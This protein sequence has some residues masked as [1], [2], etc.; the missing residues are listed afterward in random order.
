MIKKSLIVIMAIILVL[1]D[2]SGCTEE[3]NNEKDLS[4]GKPTITEDTVLEQVILDGL[5]LVGLEERIYNN[6]ELII[7]GD[8]D[9]EDNAK[10]MIIN[11]KIIIDQEYNKQ[12]SL[13]VKDSATL[14][15]DNAYYE[16][17]EWRWFNFNYYN[18]AKVQIVDFEN[19][20][21]PWQTIESNVHAEFV[22]APAGITIFNTVGRDFIGSI[23][24]E[25]SDYIYFE[26]D[27]KP[28]EKYELEFPNGFVEEW[29]PNYFEGTIDVYNST[30][31]NLDID[32]WPGVNVTVINSNHFSVGWIFGDGW[33]QQYSEGDSAEI[34]G[35]KNM[36]YED[37]T[38]EANNATLRLIN[39]TL[40]SWW[41]LVT[42]DFNLTVRECRMTDPWAYNE[43][44]FKIYDSYIF[45]MSATNNAIVEI[46][47]SVV[48]DSLVALESSTIKLYATEFSGGTTIDPQAR[49]FIDGK[50]IN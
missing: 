15:V 35:L 26:I 47:D 33:G 12:Y 6:T 32:L 3:K 25:E 9:I 22:R 41:P 8:I 20:Q 43:A 7:R 37:F 46:H 44:T 19:E 5:N 23:V 31:T 49:I 36:H 2:F 40:D 14:I 11:S 50:I 29:H 27:L 18:D 28:G 13:N 30:I 4:Q 24:I 17:L 42:G 21:E 45:Y 48:E 16:S 10:L 39:T 38:V 1:V 34:I